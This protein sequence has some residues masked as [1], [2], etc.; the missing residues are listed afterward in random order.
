MNGGFSCVDAF[1][2]DGFTF[3]QALRCTDPQQTRHHRGVR[4]LYMRRSDMSSTERG[5]GS[6]IWDHRLC[7]DFIARA[8]EQ[9][10]L[11]RRGG[12]ARLLRLQWLRDVFFLLR[13]TKPYNCRR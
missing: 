7:P 9:S 2:H 6:R 12:G 8:P 11:R 10:R 1:K 3:W 5:A 4:W 13:T